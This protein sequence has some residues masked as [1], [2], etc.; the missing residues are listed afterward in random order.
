LTFEAGCHLSILG[1]AAFAWCSGLQSIGL[2]SSIETMYDSSFQNCPELESIEDMIQLATA[3]EETDI[4][5]SRE[6]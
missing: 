6:C 3:V 4:W 1:P 2:P 5:Y